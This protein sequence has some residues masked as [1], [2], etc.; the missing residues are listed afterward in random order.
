MTSAGIDIGARTI[1]IVLFRDGKILDSTVLNTGAK[2]RERASK[3]FDE[4]LAKNGLNR[5]KL[6]RIIST[7]YGRNHFPDSDEVVSEISC[8]AAGTAYFFPDAKLVIDIGGQD[9]KIILTSGHGRVLEFAMNDRCAAGTGRF[10]EMVAGILDIGIEDI[11]G[12]SFKK[13]TACEISSMCAVFAESEIVGLLQNEIPQ[14]Q[15]LKG[16][17]RAVAKRIVS[18]MGRSFVADTIV[19]TGGVAMIRG[20]AEALGEETGMKIVLPPD[21]RITG[22]L[23]AAIIA[24]GKRNSK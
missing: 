13:S 7:G 22:A 17:F 4:I 16:V 12:L 2:P 8:H 10:I 14:E 24:A 15:I 5:K 3:A 11:S 20:V 6:K 18:M 21:P 23:G 1:D 9:S 19:F